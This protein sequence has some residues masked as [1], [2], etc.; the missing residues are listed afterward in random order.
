[1]AA[2]QREKINT[3]VVT[4]SVKIGLLTDHHDN[5][6]TVVSLVFFLPTI[7]VCVPSPPSIF[8]YV[9]LVPTH[10]ETPFADFV[11]ISI[12]R[13]NIPPHDSHEFYLFICRS[14]VY[15]LLVYPNIFNPL[16]GTPLIRTIQTNPPT[17]PT[18]RPRLAITVPGG[19][20][21]SSSFTKETSRRGDGHPP[22]R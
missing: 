16:H 11:L 2:D 15:V 9:F 6:L 3:L 22:R 17:I 1:M 14:L 21:A 7:F 4:L 10:A 8:F 20:K 18:S 13:P 5:K 19:Q 12:T